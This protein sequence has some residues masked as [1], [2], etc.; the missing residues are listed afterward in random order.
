[1]AAACECRLVVDR[2]SDL[3]GADDA[4]GDVGRLAEHI[5]FHRIDLPFETDR[6]AFAKGLEQWS[7]RESELPGVGIAGIRGSVVQN[8]PRSVGRLEVHGSLQPAVRLRV[9][10]ALR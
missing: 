7:R 10:A 4:G 1:D 8:A 5:A 2:G 6:F 9:V 3:Q